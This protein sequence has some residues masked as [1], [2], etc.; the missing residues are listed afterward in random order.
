MEKIT[1]IRPI[2]TCTFCRKRKVKCNRGQPCDTCIKYGNS[3]CIF[4]D[5]N[6]NKARHKKLMKKISTIQKKMDRLSKLNQGRTF[7]VD[8]DD[9]NVYSLMVQLSATK[10][11]LEELTRGGSETKKEEAQDKP[12]VVNQTNGEIE[13]RNVPTYNVFVPGNDKGGAATHENCKGIFPSETEINFFQQYDVVAINKDSRCIIPPFHGLAFVRVDPLFNILFKKSFE[14]L[15]GLKKLDY[16]NNYTYQPYSFHYHVDEEMERLFIGKFCND[17]GIEDF[18]IINLEKTSDEIFADYGDSFNID[19]FN[20]DDGY[21]NTVRASQGFHNDFNI[22]TIMPIGIINVKESFNHSQWLLKLKEMLP[23]VNVIGLYLD[24]FFYTIYP[25]LPVLNEKEFI[26][27]IKRILHVPDLHNQ[28]FVTLFNIRKNSDIVNLGILLVILR[29]TYTSLWAANK[30]SNDA[31]KTSYYTPTSVKLMT[32]HPMSYKAFRLAQICFMEFNP[33]NSD[34]F[35]V[36]QLGMCIRFYT[37]YGPEFGI[38]TERIEPIPLNSM[39]LTMCHRLGLT[40]EPALFSNDKDLKNFNLGRRIWYHLLHNDSITFYSLGS[41]NDLNRFKFDTKYPIESGNS[42][43]QEVDRL[44]N[45]LIKYCDSC[46]S[47]S[48][49]LAKEMC[50]NQPFNIEKYKAI[51]YGLYESIK[52]EPNSD[53]I[54]TI[55]VITFKIRCCLALDNFNISTYFHYYTFFGKLKNFTQAMKH[56]QSLLE[57]VYGLALRTLFEIFYKSISDINNCID[58]IVIPSSVILIQKCL[59][60]N[61]SILM[62]VKFLLDSNK[63]SGEFRDSLL[64]FYRLLYFSS[65]FFLKLSLNA[66]DRYFFSWRMFKVQNQFLNNFSLNIFEAFFEE[67]SHETAVE[68]LNHHFGFNNENLN[69]LSNIIIKNFKLVGIDAED[70]SSLEKIE[71][72]KVPGREFITSRISL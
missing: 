19:T 45:L 5:D 57:L 63:L 47:S 23:P 11:D 41:A 1:R 48:R 12:Q 34:D 16:L 42:S 15:L 69:L 65:I 7:G 43:N 72:W 44:S 49:I 39:L 29:V 9:N 22:S 25:F 46:S 32:N 61:F 59:L 4:Q 71:P 37:I 28:S 51:T 40:K 68:G 14:Q 8:S 38:A 31:L 17:E 10:R 56:L 6:L 58:F 30:S 36:L 26:L 53:T 52:D 62:R 66:I 55:A 3:E 18:R 13:Q 50:G 20:S 24:K 54:N 64:K 67:I 60:V 33:L 27:E 35:E 70:F 2:T 21:Y